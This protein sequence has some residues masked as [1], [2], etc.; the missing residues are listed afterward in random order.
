MSIGHARKEALRRFKMFVR[1]KYAWP[2]GYPLY[3]VMRD[4]AVYCHDC[5]KDRAAKIIR[6]TMSPPSWHADDV[7][8]GVDVNYEDNDL[9]CD[10]CNALIESAYGDD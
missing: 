4:G 8:A 6:D 3:A 10:G 5:A 2:G 7:L 1:D 9:M